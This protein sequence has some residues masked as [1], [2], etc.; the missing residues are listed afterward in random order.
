MVLAVYHR[1]ETPGAPNGG[2]KPDSGIG[3]GKARP[4][5]RLS[6]KCVQLTLIIDNSTTF[7]F[8]LSNVSRSALQPAIQLYELP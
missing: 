5:S 3:T 6:T 4:A 8:Y 1:N 7:L 2:I